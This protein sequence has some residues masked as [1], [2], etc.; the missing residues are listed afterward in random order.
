MKNVCLILE[1]IGTDYC[2]FQRQKNGLSIQEILEN[3]IF[4]AT[5]EQCKTY[6]SGRTDAGV[7]ALGQVVNFFTSSQLPAKRFKTVL[8]NILPFD[9]R[10]VDSF[11]V[12]KNFNA[13]K[14]AKK[15]TYVYQIF[16]GKDM[17]VFDV[18]RKLKC[19]YELDLELMQQGAKLFEG[20]HD[21]S[22]FVASNATTKTTIRTIYD[23]NIIKNDANII[24]EVCGNGFL[25]NMVRIM[26]GT[27]ID[28]GRGK[29]TLK[30]IEVLLSTTNRQLAGKTVNPGGLYLKKVEY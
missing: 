7:H 13:R 1:Y 8:N 30:D 15:K 4:Q 3:C 25:Y 20:T 23:A 16:N 26:V 17:S 24:F 21:F 27:L 12:D 22:S 19:E 11:E 18:N 6:P 5:Q 9:I 14:S 2:G 29:L 28:L 10:I